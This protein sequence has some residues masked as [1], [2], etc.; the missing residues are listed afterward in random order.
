[1]KA[2]KSILFVLVLCVGVNAQTENLG[3]GSFANPRAPI[4]VAVDAGLAIRQ[5]DNP[6]LMFILY[7]APQN[8]NQEITVSRDGVTMIF[9]GRELKMPSVKELRENYQG[10]VRDIDFYGHLGKEGLISSWMRF[11]R[12]PEKADFFPVNNLGSPT[13]VDQGSMLG[14]NGFA[15]KLYF[16][17][18]GFKKGDAFV[19]KVTDK[20][21]PAMSGE[22]E[23]VL[24]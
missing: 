21:N 16:K 15:T 8:Q 17:N 11:Y 7:L 24:K 5:L 20:T 23:V 10:Q 1:M 4:M 19:L 3:L 12:F 9:Q 6:Y 22:V 14:I 13:A 2:L 18:P